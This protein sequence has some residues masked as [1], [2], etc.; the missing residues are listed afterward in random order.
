MQ[1]ERLQ[2]R[3]HFQK[4]AFAFLNGQIFLIAAADGSPRRTVFEDELAAAGS[5]RRR[6]HRGDD[7][8][9]HSTVASL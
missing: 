8:Q 1:Q 9:Q 6:A 4:A 7:G 2:P 5:S 3:R